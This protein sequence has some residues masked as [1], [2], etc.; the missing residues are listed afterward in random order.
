M[1]IFTLAAAAAITL[2][3]TLAGVASAAG[4]LPA[5]HKKTVGYQDENGTFHPFAHPEPD[6]VANTTHTGKYVINFKVTIETALPAGSTIYCSADIVLLSNQVVTSPKYTDTA[7]DYEESGSGS[8]AAG[9]TGSTVTCPV[10]ITYSWVFPPATVTAT[11]T[12]VNMVSGAYTVGAYK[13]TT[14]T[15]LSSVEGVRTSSSSLPISATP[16]SPGSSSTIS[17]PATL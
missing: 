12:V 5:T 17:V 8:V 4:Q 1:R 2:G 16:L 10:V 6:V 15:T 7:I 9:A 11:D 13:T 3:V 14:V